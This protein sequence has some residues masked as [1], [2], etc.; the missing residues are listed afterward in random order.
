MPKREMSGEGFRADINGLRAWA[1]MAVVLYHFGIAG[2][3]GGF[4]GV[5]VFF[6][7][8]GF[9]MAGIIATA[10]QRGK[11]SISGFYL[12]RARRI[13][14]ALGVLGAVLLVVGWFL[15]MPNE[16][17]MLG[18]HVRDSLLF[19]SNLRYLKESGYF[20]SDAHEKWLLH[21]WSL[22]VEWQF[23]VL[24][25]ILLVAI[26]KLFPGRR[27][28]VWAHVA[29][30]LVSLAFCVLLTLEQPDKAFFVLPTRAWELLLGGLVFLLGSSFPLSLRGRRYLE[31][32]GFTLIISAIGWMDASSL[33]PGWLALIPTLGAAAVL[34]ARQEGSLWTGTRLA[35]WLGTRSYSI[36]LWHWPL[37][38]ALAYYE[39][40]GDPLWVVAGLLASLLCGQCSYAWV[41]VPARR[42][43]SR[44]SP[45]LG[46]V[47]LLGGGLALVACA[48]LVRRDGFPERLPETVMLIEAERE[49]RNPRLDE[50]LHADASC[51]YGGQ[52]V[53]A[54]VLGDSHADAAV[55][56]IAA[57]LPSTR[58]GVLFKGFSNCLM[59]FSAK[60]VFDKRSDC[61]RIRRELAA[62][63]DDLYPG[64]PV[65][66]INRA[67]AYAFG[68]FE[69]EGEKFSG[70]PT[71]YFSKLNEKA[72][73]EFLDEFRQQYI[74]T[75]CR[76]AREHPL[77][78]VRPFPEMREPVPQ[79]L[80]RS[81]LMGKQGA[82]I[83][84][85]REEYRVRH[86]FIWSVQ[87][88]VSQRCGAQILNP[89][90][91]L[92]D[93][94]YCYGSRDGWPLYVDD[95]HLSEFGNRLLV[96]MFAQVFT[97][98]P[99]STEVSA[100]ATADIDAR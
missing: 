34:M 10:L 11:F 71:V 32:C 52:D 22:S 86:A 31:W 58:Q 21:T 24:L 59:V 77:Y 26:W 1:V 64:R 60:S 33:W 62:T 69:S 65:I 55:T 89:V 46:L 63:V 78:L 88:E 27:T 56:A 83:S 41:E 53:S 48:Q 42:G 38:A 74:E 82:E 85:T 36:Y 16:Y 40:L 4:V 76:I 94:Q 93:E 15:M 6:V 7:I 5:D 54:V 2:I 97:G 75:A 67:S 90:P 39:V 20:D 92:C 61:E 9:L 8:S 79:A 12:A 72:T 25:P 14:P 29:L 81:A 50:C 57:S 44:M 19:T 17:R 66:V 30:L 18:R 84:I 87:D 13:L 80:G 99:A 28:I 49:N 68:V 47:C 23:Y 37:V 100:A 45:K 3:A 35:Q 73:P 95:D 70:R 43:L 96:P 98:N 91:Y 51:V